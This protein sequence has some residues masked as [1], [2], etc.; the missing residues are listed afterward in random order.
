MRPPLYKK[1]MLDD[2]VR[3][4]YENLSR[5]SLVTSGVYRG[6]LRLFCDHYSIAPSQLVKLDQ[7]EIED[8]LQDF[9][10]H[11]ESEG[12]AGSYLASYNKAIK[13]WCE[14]NRVYLKRK[15]RIKDANRTPTVEDEAVPTQQE[16]KRVLYSDKAPLRTRASIALM[17]FAGLRFQSQGN[18]RGADGLKVGDFPELETK[19]GRVVFSKIPAQVVVRFNLNK[20]R[21]RYISFLNEEGC[22]I[23]AE[24]LNRRA[25]K[26]EQIDQNTPVIATSMF[27]DARGKKS[28][29]VSEGKVKHL[30]SGKIGDYIHNAVRANGFKWRP[31]IFRSYFDTALMLAESKG[32]IS[33]AYQQFW[34]GHKG[35]IE[36]TYMTKK[37]KLSEDVLQ[38]MREAYQ[39]C[40][41]F[42]ST[43]KG[44]IPAE[45]VKDELKR[46]LLSVAGFKDDEIGQIDLSK[47]SDK[48]FQKMV[49]E[50]LLGAMANH[51]NKQSRSVR[52]GQE[53]D[54]A[55]MGVCGPV[56]NWRSHC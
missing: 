34:M 38:D 32:K 1:L 28:A 45:S 30:I 18:F 35:D 4:W 7:K 33:H 2:D 51:G 56:A 3:R 54:S 11:L 47:T 15:I 40:Q 42:M 49:R 20:T 6:R 21:H 10:S 13:S 27:Y 19:E 8:K 29:K 55:G 14:W 31:Y 5:G 16:L 12:K 50:K 37:G 24:F 41:S 52:R 26:G 48:E 23:V 22:S 25:E 39:R 53:P 44:G 9:F 36:S 46:Q 17:A 43:E